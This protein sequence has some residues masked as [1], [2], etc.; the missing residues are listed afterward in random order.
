MFTGERLRTLRLERGLSRIA[1][2]RAAGKTENQIRDW[3]SGRIKPG[4]DSLYDLCVALDCC[5]DELLGLGE[6]VGD[7]RTNGAAHRA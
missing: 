2:A 1:L 7:G 4:A 3:E 6:R 5:A